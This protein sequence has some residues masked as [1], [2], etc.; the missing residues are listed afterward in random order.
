MND[1]TPFL[2]IDVIN[3]SAMEWYVVEREPSHQ[4][5]EKEDKHSLYYEEINEVKTDTPIEPE[6]KE[7]SSMVKEYENWEGRIISI[8]KAF[9]RAR[10]VNTQRHYSP[11]VMQ[12]DR[13]LFYSNGINRV[14]CVGDT[15]ELTFRYVTFE[16]HNN[17]NQVSFNN[18]YVDTLRMIEPVSLTREEIEARTTEKLKKLSFLLKND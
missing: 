10:I 17:K 11:R 3:G 2:G 14:L 12:I 9:I 1:T 6:L 4:L 5:E 13:S 18:R 15:F 7:T 8:E 16:T